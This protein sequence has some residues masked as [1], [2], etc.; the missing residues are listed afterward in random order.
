M[1]VSGVPLYFSVRSPKREKE[2]KNTGPPY[3]FLPKT[4]NTRQSTL[5]LHNLR[6]FSPRG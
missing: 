5:Y 4:P 1:A 3:A 2:E 6:C